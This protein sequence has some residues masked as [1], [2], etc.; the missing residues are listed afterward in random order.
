M[1]KQS[2]RNWYPQTTGDHITDETNRIAFDSIY[3]LR[4]QVDGMKSSSKSESK[5]SYNAPS[6]QIT[7]YPGSGGASLT[8]DGKNVTKLTFVNGRLTSWS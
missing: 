6:F 1:A 5:E 3:Q 8:I 4:G 7:F 2:V